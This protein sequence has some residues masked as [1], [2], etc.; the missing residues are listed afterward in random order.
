MARHES[1]GGEHLVVAAGGAKSSSDTSGSKRCT[2]ERSLER[3]WRRGTMV[4]QRVTT[5]VEFLV[6]TLKVT[7]EELEPDLH[8]ISQEARTEWTAL[9]SAWSSDSRL[10]EGVTVPTEEQFEELEKKV[11]RFRDIVRGLRQDR[12]SGWWAG[13]WVV[14]A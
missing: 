12:R 4:T 13:I 1:D 11:R 14:G 5:R 8:L 7:S 10:R 6:R 2:M 9:Q 3:P